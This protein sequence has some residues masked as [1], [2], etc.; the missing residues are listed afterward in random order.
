M[1][2]PKNPGDWKCADCKAEITE[3]PFEPD[4]QR[5]DQLRCQ[6]CH[7]QEKAPEILREEF[8]N[9]FFSPEKAYFRLTLMDHLKE[10][11]II[12]EQKRAR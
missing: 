12:E 6:D 7:R 3:L 11:M 2:H 1:Y 9:Y 5:L 8:F 10:N 4:P